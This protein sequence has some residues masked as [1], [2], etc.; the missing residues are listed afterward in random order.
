MSLIIIFS[1]VLKFFLPLKRKDEMKMYRKNLI[2]Y[3][4]TWCGLQTFLLIFL[5]FMFWNLEE[6]I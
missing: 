5:S 4:N 2:K 3:Q 1:L 6:T